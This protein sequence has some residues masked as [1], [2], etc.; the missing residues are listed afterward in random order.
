MIKTY[1]RPVDDDIKLSQSFHVREFACKDG[2]NVVIIDDALVAFLQRIRNWAG[3]PIIISSGYRTK[4]HNSAIGGASNSY[5]VQGR[6]ADI[7]VKDRKR[8]SSR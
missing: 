5:H 1:I 6:A 8:L 2:S 4:A 3:A 7:Y